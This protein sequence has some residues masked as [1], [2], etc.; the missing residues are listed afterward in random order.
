MTEDELYHHG[1]KG[2]KWGVRRFQNKDGSYTNAGK[3]RRSKEEKA[4]DKAWNKE[5]RTI[6]R[7]IKRSSRRTMGSHTKK[8]YNDY[9]DDQASDKELH[10][11]WKVASKA[12]KGTEE[13]ARYERA[14]SAVSS[15]HRDKI[16]DAW[17]K[18]RNI[19]RASQ[20]GREYIQQY[21]F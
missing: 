2:M 4:A 6:D 17:L 9:W 21:I 5:K 12:G 10:D 19:Q 7:A 20:R 8:A 11:S 18:D 14:V 13:W 16:V 15:R 3:K 1:I